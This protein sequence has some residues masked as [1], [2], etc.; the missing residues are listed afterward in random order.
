MEKKRKA[1]KPTQTIMKNYNK[2]NLNKIKVRPTQTIRKKN[3]NNRKMNKKHQ[4]K[5][6]IT[7]KMEKKRKA[8]KPTQTIMKNYNKI[9]LNKLKHSPK[10]SNNNTH[11][12]NNQSCRTKFQMI[13][14][15]TI[16]NKTFNLHLLQNNSE[17]MIH[18]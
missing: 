12:I 10:N 14:N 18:L 13:L 1:M 8:M 4:Q 5:V 16:N 11:K 3:K 17:L 7:K 2:I 15:R 9:N 6:L